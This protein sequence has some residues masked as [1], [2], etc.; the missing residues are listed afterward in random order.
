MTGASIAPRDV[1]AACATGKFF[2]LGLAPTPTYELA[3]YVRIQLFAGAPE[4]LLLAARAVVEG[5]R[6]GDPRAMLKELDAEREFERSARA[7]Y[8][9]LLDA[10]EPAPN[11]AAHARWRCDRA[12]QRAALGLEGASSE[13]QELAAEPMADE[14]LL[15][16][17]A[18]T[19]D[20]PPQLRR[21]GI[22]AEGAQQLEATIADLSEQMLAAAAE[23]KF[24]LAAR[25]RDE[26][27]DLKK[28]L[29]SME[30]AGHA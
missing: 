18:A 17:E 7:L 26:V 19:G 15:D 9:G 25:L 8:L 3:E 22:A 23:L 30:R 20:V 1:E 10:S 28:E 12:I 21:E 13:L 27:Q 4:T 29:R 24:E 16:L 2:A 14:L 11:T 5:D 6:P